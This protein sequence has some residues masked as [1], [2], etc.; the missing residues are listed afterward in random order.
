VNTAV[1]KQVKSAQQTLKKDFT[2]LVAKNRLSS[3]SSCSSCLPPYFHFIWHSSRTARYAHLK[4]YFAF[5]SS[6]VVSEVITQIVWLS[7]GEKGRL[8]K[9]YT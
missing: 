5:N 6:K 9:E 7:V 8:H 2:S 3:C 4:I 1:I